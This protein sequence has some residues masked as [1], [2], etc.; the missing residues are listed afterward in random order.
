M[1]SRFIC[2]HCAKGKQIFPSSW[3]ISCN[4][5][6]PRWTNRSNR[7]LGRAC[8][9]WCATTGPA[10]F[11][12]CKT[13]SRVASFSPLMASLKQRLLK[14]MSHW[15][16]RFRTPLSKTRCVEKFWLLASA[17]IGS[18]E[19][20]EE[21]PLDFWPEAHHAVLQGEASRYYAAS[22]PFAGL[23]SHVMWKL[24]GKRSQPSLD[25][26]CSRGKSGGEGGITLCPVLTG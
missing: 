1:F 6:Q 19:V 23:S 26:G 21:Q 24:F 10:T 20:R 8:A 25:A 2:H 18:S 16:P 7:F 22:R 12:S 3:S 15:S 9:P 5:L 13:I 4:S 11:E 17:L 14:A